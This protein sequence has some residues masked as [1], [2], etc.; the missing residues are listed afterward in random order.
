MD[1]TSNIRK[2][3]EAMKVGIAEDQEAGDGD[4]LAGVG[5]V[6][7]ERQNKA[8]VG[9]DG[10]ADDVADVDNQTERAEYLV[11]DSDKDVSGAIDGISDS[12]KDLEKYE[13][14][15][16]LKRT[17][18]SNGYHS[19]SGE[20]TEVA[21]SKARSERQQLSPRPRKS[22]AMRIGAGTGAGYGRVR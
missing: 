3:S 21:G 12:Q 6:P 13:I 1:V 16:V 15:S 2:S 10:G 9:E 18:D 11:E 20:F 5:D 7:S 8:I 4:D 22:S 17:N 19:G 14:R